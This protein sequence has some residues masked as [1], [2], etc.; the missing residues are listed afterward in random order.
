MEDWYQIVTRSKN[1]FAVDIVS[2]HDFFR[3]LFFIKIPLIVLL[4]N[5]KFLSNAR[6]IRFREGEF[7]FVYKLVLG[8]IKDTVSLV[9]SLPIFNFILTLFLISEF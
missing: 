3:L 7:N 4:K 9:F 5:L 1:R 2:I 8:K 6:T